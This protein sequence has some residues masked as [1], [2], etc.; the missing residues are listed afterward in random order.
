M[1]RLINEIIDNEQNFKINSQ[2][3]QN[4]KQKC[5]KLVN[6]KALPAGQK[7]IAESFKAHIYYDKDSKRHKRY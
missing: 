6:V 4:D 2:E 5:P 7:T 3:A 1:K